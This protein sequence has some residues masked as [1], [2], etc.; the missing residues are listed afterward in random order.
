[1]VQSGSCWCC[2]QG[3]RLNCMLAHVSARHEAQ[4]HAGTCFCK[5]SAGLSRWEE[6][7]DAHASGWGTLGPTHTCQGCT[8]G[9]SQGD[10]CF[11]LDLI[12]CKHGSLQLCFVAPSCCYRALLD[13]TDSPA[14]RRTL[15]IWDFEVVISCFYAKLVMSESLLLQLEWPMT[16]SYIHTWSDILS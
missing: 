9:P 12:R 13:Q 7:V 3:M 6:G 4:L 8:R 15:W 10:A 2:L 1:M 5:T 11:A 14:T 16:L